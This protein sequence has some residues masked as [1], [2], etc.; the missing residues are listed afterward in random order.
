MTPFHVQ[1]HFTVHLVN[2]GSDI[3]KEVGGAFQGENIN[4]ILPNIPLTQSLD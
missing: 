4:K 2:P 1:S 3:R